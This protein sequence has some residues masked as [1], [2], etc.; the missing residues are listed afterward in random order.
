MLAAARPI[1]ARDRPVVEKGVA[2]VEAHARGRPTAPTAP[3]GCDRDRTARASRAISL[4][5]GERPELRGDV[6]RRQPRQQQRRRRHDQTTQHQR[7]QQPPREKS[8]Q[9]AASRAWASADLIAP[10]SSCRR[11]TA[12][13][14]AAPTAPRRAAARCA[15]ST[16][17]APRSRAPAGSRR[18]SAA[19]SLNSI[20]PPRRIERRR[21]LEHQRVDAP[22]PVGGRRLLRQVPEVARAGAEPEIQV[23]R[24]VEVGRAAA[25][26]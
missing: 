20:A 3:P 7:E 4:G 6:A 15:R 10:R 25:G 17:A 26:M 22:L 11:S 8:S 1:S 2:E 14:A 18:G 21:L 23:A 16:A 5:R 24:R 12:P 13:A 19:P 9:V